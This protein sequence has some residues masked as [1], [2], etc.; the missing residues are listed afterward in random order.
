MQ[1]I[2]IADIRRFAPFVKQLSSFLRPDRLKK[3]QSYRNPDDSLRCLAGGLL[4]EQI[5]QGQEIIF[6]EY[7]KPFLPAGPYFSLSHSGDFVCL[8]VSA[9]SPLGVDIERQREENFAALGRTAFHSAELD[10]FLQEPA[11]KVFFDI[12]TAKESYV[13]MVGTGFSIEPASFCILPG[14]MSFPSVQSPFFCNFNFID[15]YSLALCALEPIQV[16]ISRVSRESH[17]RGAGI[18]ILNSDLNPL[19]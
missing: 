17:L 4:V 7:G 19:T 16:S 9:S 12:W 2:Y 5:A 10:F 6:N 13:K 18:G 15:G 1:T 14:K 8:A 3:M 11:M